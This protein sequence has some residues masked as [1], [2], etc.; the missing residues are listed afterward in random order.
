MFRKR[1][2]S[3][4]LSFHSLF[5]ERP[6]VLLGL[7]NIVAM[8]MW[9]CS[10]SKH[11]DI[12]K[13]EQPCTHKMSLWQCVFICEIY[14]WATLLFLSV[15]VDLR[16]AIL[17]PSLCAASRQ[18]AS[19]DWLLGSQP[20]Q[21]WRQSKKL[22]YFKS[23]KNKHCLRVSHYSVIPPL[24][25]LFYFSDIWHNIIDL[26]ICVHLHFHLLLYLYLHIHL[27]YHHI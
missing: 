18:E 16:L 10:R 24:D 21:M 13:R 11:S 27:H 5:L 12:K 8:G 15:T 20:Q 4:L 25:N 7:L 26:H 2:V 23:A 17:F 9:S 19:R 1:T 14:F 6:Q 3:V 22:S